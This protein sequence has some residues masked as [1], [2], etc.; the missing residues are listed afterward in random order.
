[1]R[2]RLLLVIPPVFQ[3]AS[4]GKPELDEHFANNLRAY[5]Q[6]FDHVTVACPPTP[7]GAGGTIAVD[8]LEDHERTTILPLPT[9]YRED[10]Y[11]RHRGSMIDLFKAEIEKADYLLFSPHSAFD[12][13]TLAA[14]LAASMGRSY[15]MEADWDLEN[16][17]GFQIRSMPFGFNKLRKHIWLRLQMRDYRHCL[18][19]SSLALLQGQDVYEA[20]KDLA[21]NPRKVLNVQITKADLIPLSTLQ[22]KLEEVRRGDALSIVYVGRAIPMK[23]PLDWLNGLEEIVRQGVP[24]KAAW[25][26]GGDMLRELRAECERRGLSGSVQFAGPVSREEALAAVRQAHLFLFC[27]KT[28]ES[29]RCVVEALAN[30]TPIVGFDSGYVRDLVASSGGGAFAPIGDHRA[31]STLVRALDRDR[32]GLATLMEQARSSAG[33]LDREEAIRQR[34]ELIR[35]Y[36]IPPDRNAD[37]S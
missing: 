11:F 34:I 1:M 24:I 30:A 2:G 3:F 7:L 26:G 27:H 29:P 28:L 16:V 32:A 13:S 19:H 18:R 31:L 33:S 14:K 8:D 6:S 21:P 10:R 17:W 25:Y 5:L 15:D 12:W 23:G 9:P 20:Y 37:Q 22:K 4:S 35:T 36:V